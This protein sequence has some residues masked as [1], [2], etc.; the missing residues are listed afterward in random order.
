MMI[1]PYFGKS[2]FGWGKWF[3]WNRIRWRE[4]HQM[5]FILVWTHRYRRQSYAKYLDDHKD[6]PSKC[7]GCS[8]CDPESEASIQYMRRR[9]IVVI[10]WCCVW[11]GGAALVALSPLALL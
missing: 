5:P 2:N 8:I 11:M 1:I 6:N 9:H 7:K 10:F 3:Y 4:I